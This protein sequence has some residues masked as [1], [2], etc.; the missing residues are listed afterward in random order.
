MTTDN[1]QFIDYSPKAFAIIGETKPIKAQLK[2]LGGR[3][4]PRLKCGAGWIFSKRNAKEV[5]TALGMKPSAQ[6]TK[7]E[8][9]EETTAKA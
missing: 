2:K 4:N 9:R 7:I 3:F 6:E 8:P 5:A 1:L